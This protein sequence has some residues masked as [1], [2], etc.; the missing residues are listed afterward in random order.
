MVLL[1]DKFIGAYLKFCVI[2]FFCIIKNIV[3]LQG[4]KQKA[5]GNNLFKYPRVAYACRFIVDYM[6]ET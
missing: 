5:S 1:F 3:H 6:W 4:D 2:L